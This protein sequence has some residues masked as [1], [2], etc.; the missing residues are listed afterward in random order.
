MPTIQ[1][2][3]SCPVFESFRVRQVAGMF[4]MEVAQRCQESFAVELPS[5][6]E[7]WTIGAL[8]GPSGSGKTT[9]ARAAYGE[10]LVAAREWPAE[11]AVVDGFGEVPIKEIVHVLTA[12]GLGSPPAW[13]KPYHAL[14]NGER[15]RCDLARALCGESPA[16]SA[17]G[18]L[19]VFDEFTSVVDRTV[20]KVASAAVS[21][22][23]RSGRIRRRFVAVTCHYDVLEWLEPDWVADMASGRLARGRLRRPQI[24][25]EVVRCSREAWRLFARHH[26][27]SGSL[28]PTATCYMALWDGEPVAFCALVG[29]YG[30]AGRRRVTRVVT[31]PDY[32]G[33]GIG[34]RLVERVGDAERAA[35]RR[36]NITA[37]HPAIIGYC[38]RSPRW[39][40]VDVSKLGHGV[41]RSRQ[42][43]KF[44]GSQG[45]TVVSF[46]YLGEG[47]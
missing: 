47:P 39:R 25:L 22:A 24:P 42:G 6:E 30:Y 45:R 20:A 12:V 23:I 40:A 34:V 33:L 18:P 5:H 7:D 14:S 4:D 43:V 44:R 31:L 27:L 9:V 15:F 41:Q 13:I 32:Q 10:A 1:T 36:L 38:K 35:G 21:R 17:A 16:A 46:E 28:V 8:V 37:S 2:T 3:V 26:Y 19:V 29:L 11:R